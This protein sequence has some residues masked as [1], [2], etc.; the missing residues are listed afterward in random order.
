MSRLVYHAT[1]PSQE[2]IEDWITKNYEVLEAGENHYKVRWREMNL[3]GTIDIYGERV[4]VAFDVTEFE[5]ENL[6]LRRN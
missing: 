3:N 4:V 6:Q 5:K 2:G 1:F